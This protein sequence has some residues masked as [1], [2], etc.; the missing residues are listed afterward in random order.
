MK[1]KLYVKILLHTFFIL[2]TITFIVPFILMI[3]ISIS[4]EADVVDYGFKLIPMHVDFSAYKLLF[5]EFGTMAWAAVFTILVSCGSAFGTAVVCALMAYPLSRP[6]F[7]WKGPINKILIFTML[8]NG[9]LIPRYILNTQY[10]HLNNTVWIYLIPGVSAWGVILYRTFFSQI[11]ASL[12]ESAKIDGAT[13][14]VILKNVIVP[15]TKSMVMVQVFQGIVTGWNGWETSLYYITDKKLYTIQ[16]L[17]QIYLKNAG[18]LKKL[19][20]ENPIFADQLDL[21]PVETL[22]YAMAV[23][24]TFPVLVIF[25]RMQKYFSKGIAVGSVKG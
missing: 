8:F 1:Q 24:A 25:P 15:L 17:M 10:L 5:Q 4:N 11:P 13:N 16:Y 3:S 22:R 12:I 20:L 18:E 19:F 2:A 9:G 6:D 21:V 23:I 14:T 7:S